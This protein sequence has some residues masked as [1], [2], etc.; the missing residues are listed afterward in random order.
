MAVVNG[1]CALWGLI[2][3]LT[4]WVSTMVSTVNPVWRSRLAVSTQAVAAAVPK[5]VTQT[6]FSLPNLYIPV[7]AIQVN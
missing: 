2:G 6:F 5:L 7:D 1:A 3:E 4:N